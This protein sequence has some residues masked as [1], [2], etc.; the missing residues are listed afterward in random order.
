MATITGNGAGNTLVGT[1]SADA[2]FG[3]GGNDWLTGRAGDDSL[4]GGAGAD[5]LF[6]GSGADTLDGGTGR[7]VMSGGAGAD[8]FRFD[9][10]DTGDATYGHADVITDLKANDIIDLTAVDVLFVDYYATSPERGG[11]SIWEASGNAYITWNT[12]G[13]MHDIVVEG[14]G[15]SVD[16]L[17]AQIRWYDDDNSGT[18]GTT[19]AIGAGQTRT[20]TLEVPED[21]DWFRIDLVAGKLYDFHVDGKEDGFGSA[22]EPVLALYDADGNYVDDDWGTGRM[23]YIAEDSGT[24]F[25]AVGS[26]GNTAGTYRLGVTSKVYAG[27]DHG[28]DIYTA[29]KLGIGQSRTGVIATRD[30]VDAFAI[31]VQAGKTYQIDLAG[32]PGAQNPLDDP[33]MEVVNEFWDTIAWDD[34][35]GPGNDARVTFTAVEDATY[36]IGAM[37]AYAGYGAYR[38]SVAEID[39]LA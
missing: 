20:G 1:N 8:V 26:S 37:D 33:Y 22:H 21:E 34:D 35:S 13:T 39:A 28:D 16:D 19:A 9:D 17:L 10:K 30:D 38:I 14:Y 12:F 23:P 5:R 6:G 15:G 18:T 7:D 31:D 4:F 11:L 32:R 25:L 24:Y 2:I 27:D 36:F 3:Y 29:T